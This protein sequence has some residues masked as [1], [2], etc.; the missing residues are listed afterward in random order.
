MGPERT[1]SRPDYGLDAPGVVRNFLLVGAVGVVVIV[2]HGLGVWTARHWS[3]ALLMPL[4]YLGAAF[5]IT[6]LWMVYSSRVGKV[7]SREHYLDRLSWR[8]D[9]T[10]L[11]V[12]CGRGLFLVAAARRLTR[13]GRAVGIDLWNA[14][15]LAGN[16]SD[17]TLRN[18]QLEGVADR[19]DV[20]TGDARKLPFPDA[21]F[22]TVLSSVAL[23]NI[24][25]ERGRRQAVGEVAR[26]LKPGGHV[27]IV[28]IRHTSE[29]ADELRRRGLPGAVARRGPLSYLATACTFGSLRTGTVTGQKSDSS[30][31]PPHAGS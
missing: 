13:G 27:L 6:G 8:G 23:H 18:A 29:Y 25:D 19:V 16:T 20:K 14:E 3:A 28:D 7:R 22:D 10:V 11:D 17:A 2:L 21:N 12:G 15:D 4:E 31:D 5:L 26:V 1:S 30:A 9:E 24:Y